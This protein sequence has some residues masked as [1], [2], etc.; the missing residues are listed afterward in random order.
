[1][2]GYHFSKAALRALDPPDAAAYLPRRGAPWTFDAEGFSRDV[3]AARSTGKAVWPTYD[4]VLSDPVPDGAVLDGDAI[5]LCEGNYLLLGALA[6]CEDG[7]VR[8]EAERWAPL[9]GAFDET[10]YVSPPDGVAD[11]RARLIDRHL[12]TW[13]G[14]KTAA[15]GAATARDGA[16]LRTDANDVP[17]ALLVDRC[18]PFAD[19][20]VTTE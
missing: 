3:V 14:E 18:R 9:L 13:T 19:H 7:A 12:E 16:A 10:W 15:W 17:N 6:D 11:Q 1:M 2:D 4:R 20:F 5:V 8:A